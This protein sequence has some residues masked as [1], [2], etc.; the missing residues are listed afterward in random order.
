MGPM[1]LHP[2]PLGWSQHNRKTPLLAISSKASPPDLP[3]ELQLDGLFRHQLIHQSAV[4]LLQNADQ[5]DKDAPLILREL[6]S[7]ALT[8][9]EDTE[10]SPF[11]VPGHAPPGTFLLNQNV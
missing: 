5:S 1:P 2:A 9:H 7:P 8:S 6:K 10:F 4:L 3:L 11:R